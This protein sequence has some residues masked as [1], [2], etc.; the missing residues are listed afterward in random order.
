MPVILPR[1]VIYR[2]R[3]VSARASSSEICTPFTVL[4]HRRNRGFSAISSF[5]GTGNYFYP[6]VIRRRNN[7]S[8][9]VKEEA[10]KA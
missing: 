7:Y 1:L 8:S 4:L 5:R 6:K 3:V 9:K 10:A 2:R